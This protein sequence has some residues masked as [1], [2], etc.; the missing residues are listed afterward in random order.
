MKQ[1]AFA[2]F[3]LVSVVASAA[4][5]SY[6]VSTSGVASPSVI[7]GFSAST[8]GSGFGFSSS[9]TLPN[10]LVNGAYDLGP[11]EVGSSVIKV[12]PIQNTSGSPVRALSSQI[13]SGNSSD[14]VRSVACTP[15]LTLTSA[16]PS[17]VCGLSL[18]VTPSSTG[19]RSV[20]I[21]VTGI[22]SGDELVSSDFTFSF[23][24]A[25]GNEVIQLSATEVSFDDTAVDAE[26]V[27]Q[28]IE[29]TN[30]GSVATDSL[31]I[32]LEG[33]NSNAFTIL[34]TSS[35][36]TSQVLTPV[37]ETGES[38][39][40]DVKFNPL[41]THKGTTPSASIK[42]DATLEGASESHSISLIGNIAADGAKPAL[43]FLNFPAVDSDMAP[44]GDTYLVGGDKLARV[45]PQGVITL[46]RQLTSPSGATLKLSAVSVSPSGTF[47]IAGGQLT[48]S[49]GTP[50]EGYVAKLS[51]AGDIISQVKF[52]RGSPTF[53]T[54]VVTSPS[55]DIF[56]AI[57]WISSDGTNNYSGG[58]VY[59]L[60]SDLQAYNWG[61]SLSGANNIGAW[62]SLA[63]DN[64]GDL[65]AVGQTTVPVSVSSYYGPFVSIKNANLVVRFNSATGAVTA[66]TTTTPSST[67][68]PYISA[69]D[70]DST[71]IVSVANMGKLSQSIIN[72]QGT[73]Q[74]LSMEPFSSSGGYTTYVSHDS[75]DNILSSTSD[76]TLT[77]QR[78][79][80][81]VSDPSGQSS[82]RYLFEGFN[83]KVS[84]PTTPILPANFLEKG[85]TSSGLIKLFNSNSTVH[86]SSALIVYPTGQLSEGN[87][88]FNNSVLLS[89]SAFSAARG[90]FISPC[91]GCS[92]GMLGAPIAP[93][94]YSPYILSPID[95]DLQDPSD[96]TASN[97]SVS[98]AAPSQ[99]DNFSVTNPV[100]LGISAPALGATAPVSVTGTGFTGSISWSPLVNSVFGRATSYTATISLTPSANYSLS[101]IPAN[102]FSVA[103]AT[104]V[105]NNAGSGVV[106]VTFPATSS[107]VP[108]PYLLTNSLGS[109][110][111]PNPGYAIL[112]GS[113]SFVWQRGPSKVSQAAASNFCATSN[114]LGYA[115][116]TWRLPT[117]AELRALYWLRWTNYNQFK[118]IGVVPGPAWSS[119][120]P[121]P[122]T[123]DR[124][125]LDS[126]SYFAAPASSSLYYAYPYCVHD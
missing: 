82:P 9:M 94:T 20:T 91:W 59:K 122:T 14:V 113:S 100:I 116:G 22:I 62:G 85:G 87:T 28:S 25:G 96:F 72:A 102:F 34:P 3:L 114:A 121:T 92:A 86:E 29:V 5:F 26:S 38:C 68:V 1:L 89:V 46:G 124:V 2:S 44:T 79:V 123:A 77:S 110:I 120:M 98:G 107:A 60:T 83:I 23:T 117:T 41:A 66:A 40:I 42:L 12:L 27:P 37:S 43:V 45:S 104:S 4:D 81:L 119:V 52:V 67:D 74:Y 58:H 126:G 75:F 76:G 11:V 55:G 65:L 49:N 21:R 69:V 35:C 56:T 54:D 61:W 73:L 80:G 103:G 111:P 70:Q 32:Q 71:G 7:D 24:G 31:S 19:A 112:D 39:F 33:V 51:L 36:L 115:S 78:T 97:S 90:P 118:V 57:K 93:W 64:A 13:V 18:K 84:S 88:V 106:T 53:V 108:S 50:S 15:P 47:L 8:P 95:S 30:T 48:Y 16:S 125:D 101:S 10:V 105:Q 6:Q 17:E 63:I 109:T 99:S